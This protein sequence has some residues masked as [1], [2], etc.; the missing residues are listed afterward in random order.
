MPI[1]CLQS[2]C[3]GIEF[4]FG[5]WSFVSTVCWS[6]WDLSSGALL[7]RQPDLLMGGVTLDVVSKAQNLLCPLG[8]GLMLRCVCLVK[9]VLFARFG[10]GGFFFPSLCEVWRPIGKLR[11]GGVGV[12]A[13]HFGVDDLVYVSL[14]WPWELEHCTLWSQWCM[15]L[16]S[17]LCSHAFSKLTRLGFDLNLRVFGINQNALLECYTIWNIKR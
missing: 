11:V 4:F 12:T 8:F 5:K 7:W 3:R 2:G 1:S 13:S 14:K 16:I 9:D 17:N 10:S 6:D 15:N